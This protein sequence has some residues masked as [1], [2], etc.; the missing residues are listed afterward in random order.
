MLSAGVRARE[1]TVA[2]TDEAFSAVAGTVEADS[3]LA[4]LREAV[5]AGAGEGSP[6]PLSFFSES[7]F[8]WKNKMAL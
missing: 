5:S 4:E 8:S 1:S 2:G 7:S 3:A 6:D